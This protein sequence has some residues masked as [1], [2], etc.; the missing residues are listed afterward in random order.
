[1]RLFVNGLEQDVPEE[2]T[3]AQL[4]EAEGEP[5]DH[6]VV[7]INGIYLPVRQYTSR[8]LQDGDRVEIILPAFG[9]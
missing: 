1:M 8:V 6:V 7:E 4:L 5:T 3:V 9:G 2:L